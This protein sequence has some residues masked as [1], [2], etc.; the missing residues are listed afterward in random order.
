MVSDAGTIHTG[1]SVFF[2][3]PIE[4]VGMYRLIGIALACILAVL[5]LTILGSNFYLMS[6]RYRRMSTTGLYLIKHRKPSPSSIL[7][8]LQIIE[9]NPS[10]AELLGYTPDELRNMKLVGVLN[11]KPEEIHNQLLQ[12]IQQVGGVRQNWPFLKK[13]GSPL[14]LEIMGSR[15]RYG[16][17]GQIL[18]FG[19]EVAAV[20]RLQLTE[21]LGRRIC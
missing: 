8:T 6:M 11:L 19:R 21:M 14:T 15:F 17:K 10:L 4:P 16:G 7:D 20:P 5:A 1:W 18:V 3:R 2:F 13:D 9:A 12:I